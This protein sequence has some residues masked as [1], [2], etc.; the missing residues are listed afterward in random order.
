M[1][2]LVVYS[3]SEEA[4]MVHSVVCE[5]RRRNITTL[6]LYFKTDSL[7]QK[8]TSLIGLNPDITVDF[9][10]EGQAVSVVSAM[11]ETHAV[12]EEFGADWVVLHGGCGVTLSAAVSSRQAGCRIAHIGSGMR[13]ASH[14]RV[15]VKERCRC[16]G[17]ALATVLAAPTNRAAT[18]LKKLKK[19]K[20]ILISGS[21]L[22]DT[23]IA[24]LRREPDQKPSLPYDSSEP[25]FLISVEKLGEDDLRGVIAAASR[26]R[27][28]YPEIK[29]FLAKSDE[30]SSSLIKEA[31]QGGVRLISGVSVL[32]SVAAARK[33]WVVASDADWLQEAAIVMGFGF[34]LLKETTDRPEA[35]DT[36]WAVLTGLQQ[37]KV[38]KTAILMLKRWVPPSRKTVFGNGKS[39]P[40][41]VDAIIKNQR[42]SPLL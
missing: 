11:R 18:N 24:F 17:E 29:T 40:L 39:A 31:V 20:K 37:N 32:E 16:C 41:V 35:L 38:A 33:G 22:T 4:L 21:T 19:K 2:V 6:T 26:V 36:G 10:D 14:R 9:S 28:I 23:L 5:L 34:I 42:N 27:T 8:I 1:R 12:I 7:T 30:M 25:I 13:F 3:T 15:P